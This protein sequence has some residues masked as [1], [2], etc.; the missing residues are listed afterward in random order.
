MPDTE[1]C[2]R[3]ANLRG[4]ALVDRLSG[5]YAMAVLGVGVEEVESVL[6]DAPGWL[7]VSA[8]NG[9]SSTVVSGDYDAVAAAVQLAGRRGIFT[10]Q[11]S[12]DYPGH[13]SA[14]RPLRSA[15]IELMPESA[16]LPGDA[17]FVGSTFGTEVNGDI[18]F[19]E[20]WYENLCG[21]VHFDRAM[22]YAQKNG[23]DTFVELSAHPS[24]L[25][26]LADIVDEES[27]VIV[28][29]GHR[30]KLITDSL[31][32][33]VAAVATAHP[34]TPWANALPGGIQPPLRR[35]PN[36]PM[37]AVHLW[38]TPEPLT[39]TVAVPALT[40]AV[41]KWQQV[42]SPATASTTG[43]AIGFFGEATAGALTQRL[44]EAVATHDGCQAVPLNEADIVVVIA[45]ELDQLDAS[46]AIEQIAGRR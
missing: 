34:G 36:A 3:P 27:A 5:R 38:A 22:R 29:S 30:D 42:T 28:G 7:E 25:F 6:A 9:P 26:P 4:P 31:S 10:H 19:S 35:F 37:R 21:T 11:L 16:F 44:I 32:A 18:D 39:D 33:S 20:Y 23:V 45:P 12:V 14:L 46:A 24:L 43:C 15:L 13:T 8:V 1:L 17:R 2:Q 41:E 40:I